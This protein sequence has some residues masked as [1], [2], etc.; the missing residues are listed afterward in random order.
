VVSV[1]S[2][3][4]AQCSLKMSRC[5][6][7]HR[8]DEFTSNMIGQKVVYSWKTLLPDWTIHEDD[9]WVGTEGTVI[10]V[11][12][13]VRWQ[14]I[15]SETPPFKPEMRTTVEVDFGGDNIVYRRFKS[16]PV[17]EGTNPVE[18]N[19]PRGHIL[20]CRWKKSDFEAV[21]PC[22]PPSSSP[23]SQPNHLDANRLFKPNRSCANFVVAD[24][25]QSPLPPA[26]LLDVYDEH[27][28]FPIE[29]RKITREVNLD[30]DI[31]RCKYDLESAMSAHE[32]P[33]YYL[34][35][36]MRPP[37]DSLVDEGVDSDYSLEEVD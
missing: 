13:G 9:P 34:E 30:S 18:R 16:F 14:G 33:M 11:R 6:G 25:L 23:P 36:P 24:R 20:G 22:P 15:Y 27:A 21:L 3:T 1:S 28:L 10:G 2:A 26:H 4:I 8:R 32:T 29:G 37:Y 19:V 5:G 7:G 35:V 12:H 17:S 31:R